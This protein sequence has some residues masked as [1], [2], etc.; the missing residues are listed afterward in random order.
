[1]APVKVGYI[2]TSTKDQNPNVQRRDRLAF[3]R[4]RI[5]EE[6]VSSRKTDRPELRAALEFCREGDV[7]VV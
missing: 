1:M 5:F 2:R 4:E 6:Q 3:G 7:L